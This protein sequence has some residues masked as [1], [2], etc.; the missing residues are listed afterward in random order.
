MANRVLDALPARSVAIVRAFTPPLKRAQRIGGV[1]SVLTAVGLAA[2]GVGDRLGVWLAPIGIGAVAALT[3]LLV[4]IVVL[5]PSM[6]RAFEAYS[7][8][9]HREVARFRDRTGG[10]V[11]TRPTQMVQWLATTPSTPAMRFPRVEILAFLGRHD[12]AQAELET[13]TSSDPSGAFE[14]ATLRQYI[15][16]LRTG[17][18]DFSDLR[19]AADGLPVGSPAQLEAE[20]TLALSEARIRL[21]GGDPTWTR[22]LEDVRPRLGWAA[23]RATL[24]DTWRWVYVLFVIIGSATAGIAQVLRAML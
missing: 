3:G 24:V 5:P 12:E 20:V 8:L 6:R 9:G 13:A 21:V 19:A 15:E 7:W 14:I 2:I 4:A 17:S 1:V 10:P 11:P 23:S 18:T 16:W 22:Q